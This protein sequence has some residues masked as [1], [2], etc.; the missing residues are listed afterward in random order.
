MIV[1]WKMICIGQLEKKKPLNEWINENN[2]KVFNCYC[3]DLWRVSVGSVTKKTD[4]SFSSVHL[5]IIVASNLKWNDI[6]FEYN[7]FDFDSRNE[8]KSKRNY[9]LQ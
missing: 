5:W 8:K 3:N 7:G 2:S 6:Q 9:F 1:Q 4:L